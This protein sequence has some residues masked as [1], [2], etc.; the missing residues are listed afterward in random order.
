[1][2]SLKRPAKWLAAAIG[3][4]FLLIGPQTSAESWATTL[5]I[6]KAFKALLFLVA[7]ATSSWGAPTIQPSDTAKVNTGDAPTAP[8][9]S[10]INPTEAFSY[11][12]NIGWM[13]WRPSVADGVEIDEYVVSGYIYGANVG[14]INMGDGTPAN[15][16]QYSN[17]SAADFGVNDQIDPAL[18]G[19]A[20]LRGFAYGANIGWINFESTG[21]PRLRFSDGRL[22]GYAYSANV[23]WINLGDGTFAV[24]T[25]FIAPGLDTDGDGMADAFETLYLGGLAALPNLDADGD[26]MTNQ[27]E[28]LE[29]TNPALATDRL[30]ITLYSTN[31]GGTSSP[32]T[33]TS[34]LSR[35]YQ[36][37][38]NPSVDLNPAGWVNDLTFGVITPD[39]GATT[40]RTATSAPGNKR[41]YRV[42]AI[43]PL[44]P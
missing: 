2:A 23:G 6:M 20:I 35:L 10:T 37:E 29:G 38:V 13:N 14:W 44:V 16:I 21:N 17:S 25:D 9:T 34:N 40:S 41:F 8:L 1:R 12:A 22:E 18:P 33:W 7:L 5:P 28:Y 30:R 43:R 11:G 15:N 32:L 39:V 19:P 24:K 31:P 42:R 4:Y 36:I 27:Q 3:K 26:G